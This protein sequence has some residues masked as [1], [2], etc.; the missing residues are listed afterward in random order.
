MIPRVSHML[1]R[2]HHMVWGMHMDRHCSASFSKRLF[3]RMPPSRK[4]PGAQETVCGQID[5]PL[6][7]KVTIHCS[8]EE[9]RERRVRSQRHMVPSAPTHSPSPYFL[10]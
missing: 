9:V 2:H 10:L 4:L 5:V 1:L 3:S 7:L 6:S 8:L